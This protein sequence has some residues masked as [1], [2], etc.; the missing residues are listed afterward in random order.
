M[1]YFRNFDFQIRDDLLIGF[2]AGWYFDSFDLKCLVKLPYLFEQGLT[3]SRWVC[4]HKSTFQPQTFQ[5]FIILKYL[6]I[7]R[8]YLDQ[9]FAS[10]HSK[11]KFLIDRGVYVIYHPQKVHHLNPI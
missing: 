7:Q 5:I 6:S 11:D 1:N 10:G 2:L 8:E 9:G 4:D 3:A